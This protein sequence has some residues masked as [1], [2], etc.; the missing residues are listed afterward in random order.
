MK[1][2]QT[3]A[4]AVV[5]A[6]AVHG[7]A[8][9]RIA[10]PGPYLG[11]NVGY[12]IG[13][14]SLATTEHEVCQGD[15]LCTVIDASSDQNSFGVKAFGGYLFN[16]YF[17]VEGGY[18][19]LGEYS[20]KDVTNGGETYKGTLTS[21]GV[22]V[23]AVAHLPILDT[24]SVFGRIGVMY[25]GM[26]K[27]YSYGPGTLIVNGVP[28]DMHLTKWDV[29][30]KFGAGVQYDF[31]PAVGI[32]GE[33][34]AYHPEEPGSNSGFD[35]NLYS[36]GVVYRFGIPEPEPE[37]IIKEVEIPVP[38]VK[39]VPIPAEPTVVQ[40]TV[41]KE[42]VKVKEVPKPIIIKGPTERVVLASDT[43]F[44]FDKSIV[45][46]EGQAALKQLA[47]RLQKKDRLIVV[48]NTDSIGTEAYNMRL[49]QRRADAVRAVLIQ[50]GI[51]PRQ[52]ETRAMGESHPVATNATDEGR[53]ANRR[54]EIEVYAAPKKEK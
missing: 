13:K 54:V 27:D 16:E 1:T 25:A 18:F 35:V 53:A 31:T 2:K 14:V 49:S 45:K 8:V 39:E 9:E 21:Q 29:G 51:S 42:V 7:Q 20:F 5:L 3:V 34:E 22:N 52:I 47:A 33:W 40:T 24:L 15:P 41:V 38:V 12:A 6:A 10:M 28:K 19:Y 50:N 4:A 44:D 11:V 43:L 48:G 30:Y 17:A 32:R 36:I 46:T 23:D 37:I 26:D